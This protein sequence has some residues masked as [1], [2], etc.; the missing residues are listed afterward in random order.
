MAASSAVEVFVVHVPEVFLA[1]PLHRHK[2]AVL[3]GMLGVNSPIKAVLLGMFGANSPIKAVLLGMLGRLGL[4]GCCMGAGG[5]GWSRGGCFQ[6][7][8]YY[9]DSKLRGHLSPFS[10]FFS[11]FQLPAPAC[12][13]MVR[14]L[15]ARLPPGFRAFGRLLPPVSD[16]GRSP[17]AAALL[18]VFTSLPACRSSDGAGGGRAGG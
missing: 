2:D 9:K 6:V 12:Q 17:I 5:V 3:L 1:V 14:R 7:L 10:P 16:A 4:R 15:P 13:P 18:P 8:F 11:F